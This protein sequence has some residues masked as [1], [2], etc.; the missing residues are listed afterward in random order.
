MTS[1]IF[2]DALSLITPKGN[3]S[4]ENPWDVRTKPGAICQVMLFSYRLENCYGPIELNGSFMLITKL[5]VIF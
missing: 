4:V 3:G 1:Q 5:P 2:R